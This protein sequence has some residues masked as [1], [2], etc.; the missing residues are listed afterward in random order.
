V[1]IRESVAAFDWDRNAADLVRVLE[2]RMTV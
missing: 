1:A 2:E